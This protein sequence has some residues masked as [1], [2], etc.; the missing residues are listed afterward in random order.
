MRLIVFGAIIAIFSV[1]SAHEANAENNEE[2]GELMP[3][4][5]SIKE[6][7]LKKLHHAD[8]K[9]RN[10]WLTRE[11]TSFTGLMKWRFSKNPF[12]EEKK[13][14]VGFPLSKP[15]FTE[16][17]RS[18]EDY[19]VWLG[20]ST[21]VIKANGAHFITDPV[22]GDINFFLKRKTSLPIDPAE[23]PKIDFVLISHGHYDHLNTESVEFLHKTFDP[24]FIAGPGYKDYFDSLDI[25]KYVAIDW[26]EA[27][28][29]GDVRVTSLPV[30][31]WSKRGLF[32]NNKMLWC[33]FLIEAD[34][35]KY[36]WAGDTGY[37]RGFKEI[38]EQFGPIDVAFLPIGAYEPRWF[39]KSN[40]INPEEAVEVAHDIK[41]KTMVPIHWGTFD[42]TDEPLWM[43]INHLKELHPEGDN[44]NLIILEHGG[45][46]AIGK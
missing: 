12:E 30:Q 38:G 36:F 16:L 23:L 21:V 35:K 43:P 31:H 17:E 14:P 24:V 27:N 37:F 20:H 39:M 18:G 44:P 15:N 8:G 11:L 22:F 28:D 7:S 46:A 3:Q 1:F 26:W 29:F 13:K 32:D 33:S 25:T 34:A 45:D 5:M 10:P 6:A 42:L 19:A 9:F 2:A 40:H 4:D 41:A